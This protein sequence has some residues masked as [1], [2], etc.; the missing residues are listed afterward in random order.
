MGL[1]HYFLNL[2]GPYI[3]MLLSIIHKHYAW[4]SGY[5]E[6][7]SGSGMRTLWFNHVSD[8]KI[9]GKC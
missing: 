6:T 1:V 8:F 9:V 4:T 7:L 2:L 5:T 3:M